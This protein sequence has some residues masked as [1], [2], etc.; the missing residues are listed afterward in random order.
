MCCW[1]VRS[2][3]KRAEQCPL[4]RDERHQFLVERPPTKAGAQVGV[5]SATMLLRR[6]R[7]AGVSRKL[8]VV[9]R[10]VEMKSPTWNSLLWSIRRWF[11]RV[12][13]RLL[14]RRID[15]RTWGGEP[16]VSLKNWSWLSWSG[17][18]ATVKATMYPALGMRYGLRTLPARPW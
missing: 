17:A 1:A 10:V 13:R 2:V 15:R 16:K 6:T 7:I 3:T 5:V 9:V 8:G 4:C 14:R 12:R 18:S 11:S